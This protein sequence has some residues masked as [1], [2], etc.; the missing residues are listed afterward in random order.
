MSAPNE[1]V[2]RR[3]QRMQGK[4]HPVCH[5]SRWISRTTLAWPD[6]CDCG[7]C[8]PCPACNTGEPPQM[9]PEFV[10]DKSV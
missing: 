9:D 10:P 6:G 1:R 3:A 8:K 4:A 2:R 5:G 7:A